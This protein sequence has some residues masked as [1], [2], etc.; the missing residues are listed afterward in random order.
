M[1]PPPSA[2]RNNCFD[3][4]RLVLALVVLLAHVSLYGGFGWD[5]TRSLTKESIS[6]ASLAVL[7]FFGLSG[8][9]ISASCASL[10]EEPRGSL[11]F[12][13]R[14]FLRIMPGFWSCQLITVFIAC[15]LIATLRGH[16]LSLQDFRA[17]NGAFDYLLNNWWL[18]IKQYQITSVTD[19]APYGAMNGSLWSLFPEAICYLLTLALALLGG[20]R[21]NRWLAVVL[22]GFV[23][24][25]N[26]INFGNEAYYGPTAIVLNRW[27]E[28]LSSYFTGMVVFCF[29]DKINFQGWPVAVFFGA[30]L[31]FLARF[32]GL[33]LFAPLFIPLV[34]LSLGQL[35]V[36]H[37]KHDL[38]YGI[39]IYSSVVLQLFA[40]VQ[41]IHS[42]YWL[43]LVCSLV[44]TTAIAAFSW[45]FIESPCIRFGRTRP[46]KRGASA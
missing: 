42:R 27:Y 39:Y 31:V 13:R 8:F 23:A 34:L 43:Y 3:L 17:P 28:P 46:S 35:A 2:G 15:P 41:F 24:T 9:L 30:L 20:L 38:S 19:G 14:R 45:K 25:L 22:L 1:K 29:R 16:P 40:A 37:V 6:I 33:M 10:L 7:G 44:T 18:Q 26:I 21:E 12:L 11:S 4:I 5:W 36:V 32:G